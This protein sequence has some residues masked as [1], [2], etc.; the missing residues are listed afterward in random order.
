ML[1]NKIKGFDF[2]AVVSKQVS[3]FFWFINILIFDNPDNPAI[4]FLSYANSYHKFH[5]W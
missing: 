5:C 3:L 2:V 4:S 1:K